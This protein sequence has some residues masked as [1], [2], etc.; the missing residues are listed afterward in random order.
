M[1]D[2]TEIH[3]TT[4]GGPNRMMTRVETSSDDTA[5]VLYGVAPKP[6]TLDQLDYLADLV[7]ELRAMSG[8]GGVDDAGWHFGLGSSRSQRANR[9]GEITPSAGLG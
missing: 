7:A 9:A 4:D 3:S 2:M 6:L 1:A 8:S 5:P